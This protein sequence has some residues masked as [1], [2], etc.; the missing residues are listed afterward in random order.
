MAEY[1]CRRN[2]GQSVLHGNSRGIQS[3][4]FCGLIFLAGA[5]FRVGSV[6]V[7]QRDYE[8]GRAFYQVFLVLLALGTIGWSLIVFGFVSAFVKPVGI[9]IIAFEKML[10]HIVSYVILVLLLAVSFGLGLVA[11]RHSDVLRSARYNTFIERGESTP[12]FDQ[13][14]PWMIPIHAFFG[15]VT[16]ADFDNG[17]VVLIVVYLFICVKLLQSMNNAI[18]TNIFQNTNKNSEVEYIYNRC[19][20]V[21]EC[22]NFVSSIPPPFSLALIIYRELKYLRTK[23]R[24]PRASLMA[25]R[26]ARLGRVHQSEFYRSKYVHAENIKAYN[27]IEA[28]LQ[29]IGKR[30]ESLWDGRDTAVDRLEQLAGRFEKFEESLEAMR[31]QQESVRQEMHQ[32]NEQLKKQVG[33]TA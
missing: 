2:A 6:I 22:S 3:K 27:S 14:Q 31:Q 32:E 12:F 17:S 15:K 20:F 21:Y 19:K 25:P 11:L 7:R 8:M 18:F 26:L 16:L 24:V 30:V 28:H 13:S 29:R 23:E 33:W 5:F 10:I 1:A 9:L 4:L